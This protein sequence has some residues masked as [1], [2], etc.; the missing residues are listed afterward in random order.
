MIPILYDAAETEFNS[1]GLGRLIDCISIEVN[2]DTDG[3]F[4]LEFKYPAT[5]R[6]FRQIK[7][8]SY[9][10][11]THDQSRVPQPFYIYRKSSEI[12][13]VVTYNAR[14][15]KYRLAN[16][17]VAPYSAANAVDAVAGISTHALTECAFRFATNISMTGDFAIYTPMPA[18]EVLLHIIETYGGEVVWSSYGVSIMAHRGSETDVEI[19][20]GKDLTELTDTIDASDTY[21]AVVPYWYQETE[22][23]ETGAITRTLVT[24]S[25]ISGMYKEYL[26]DEAGDAIMDEGG[27]RIIVERHYEH[28]VPLD[29]SQSFDEQPTVGQLDAAAALYLAETK[30]W[31]PAEDMSIN[32]VPLWQ[33]EEYKDVLMFRHV[34]LY[35]YV[36]V[37]YPAFDIQRDA[38]VVKVTYNPLTEL[39]TSLTLQAIRPTFADE[40]ISETEGM[41]D[42]ATREALH[43]TGIM[44]E[45]SAAETLKTTDTK[46]S[47]ATDQIMQD[48]QDMVD[49]VTENGKNIQRVYLPT[50]IAA[51]G[52]VTTYVQVKVTKGLIE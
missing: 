12:A 45:K 16:V 6:L 41:I 40:L 10:Y 42:K 47:D 28:A 5:G 30:P 9:I 36:R 31:I 52:T 25:K 2:Q 34:I 17:I 46:I 18:T 35:D 43:T 3:Y 21:N 22:D 51:D 48:T 13:G 23:T 24:G 20:Y 1:E 44:I 49:A 33:T 19:R 37:Y 26:V 8:D 27:N 11:T 29:L 4:E 39:Y 7:L 38:R 15:I 50:E 14:H 32:F